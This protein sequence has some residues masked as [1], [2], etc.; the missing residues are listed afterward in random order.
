[1]LVTRTNEIISMNDIMSIEKGENR[2][3][4]KTTPSRSPT[5][6]LGAPFNTEKTATSSSGVDV[7]TERSAKPTEVSPRPVISMRSYRPYHKPGDKRQN[8]QRSR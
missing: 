1:M 7:M 6:K 5:D 8:S 4:K 3:E 2:E